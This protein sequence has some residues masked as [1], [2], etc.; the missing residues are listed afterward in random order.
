MAEHGKI[1]LGGRW[2]QVN[3]QLRRK[4]GVRPDSAPLIPKGCG[5]SRFL[6]ARSQ[7]SQRLNVVLWPQDTL[8]LQAVRI[9]KHVRKARRA[10]ERSRV[11]PCNSR[12]TF[13][14]SIVGYSIGYIAKSMGA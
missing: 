8:E 5:W 6:S 1:R 7:V 13:G 10:L 3:R 2:E 14:L 11:E 9:A 12:R 4:L